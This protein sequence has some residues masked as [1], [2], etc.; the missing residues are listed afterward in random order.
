VVE[1]AEVTTMTVNFS[2]VAD[3]D[4]GDVALEAMVTLSLDELSA[5]STTEEGAT[6]DGEETDEVVISPAAVENDPLEPTTETEE[7]GGEVMLAVEASL[8]TLLLELIN[9]LLAAGTTV[10]NEVN[11]EGGGGG[12]GSDEL[13]M[14]DEA[15][16]ATLLLELVDELLSTSTTVASEVD[17]EDC[18]GGGCDDELE[19]EA[20]DSFF[21][22][23]EAALEEIRLLVVGSCV[24]ELD[25]ETDE[26]G[27]GG[28]GGKDVGLL[29]GGGGAG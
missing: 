19:V 27:G 29:E 28:G 26:G 18:G 23:V 3:E 9:E 1:L 17:E 6:L 8:P 14:I 16:L 20:V 21:A 7:L 22:V 10:V 13:E 12:G 15:A 11:E 5:W 24:N 2:V 25:V 4:C